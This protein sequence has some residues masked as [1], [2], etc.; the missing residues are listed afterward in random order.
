MKTDVVVIGGGVA[1]AASAFFLALQGMQVVVLDKTRFPRDKVCTSTVNPYT[2]T[3]LLQMG[4]MKE[5]LQDHMLPIEGMQGFSYDGNSFRGYYDEHYPYVNF[6]YT[7]P[8]YRLDLAM[9]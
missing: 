8:R 9:V 4:V 7:I 2:M 6:G 5:L 3:Y 1:G